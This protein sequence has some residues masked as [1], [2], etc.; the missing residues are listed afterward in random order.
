MLREEEPV[1]AVRNGPQPFFDAPPLGGRGQMARH[2]A[3]QRRSIRLP[4]FDY[5]QPGAYTV[6]ICTQPGAPM[7]GRITDGVV[8]LNDYGKV[9]EDCWRQIPA[10]IP[11]VE[12]DA[13]VV[14]PNH[15]HGI[16]V[17]AQDSRGRGTAC[18][19]PTERFGQPVPGSLP[20]L[21]RSFKSAATR[22]I[23]KLR[24]TPGGRVWQRGYYERVIRNERELNAVRRY[25][26]YNPLRRALDPENPA[27]ADR[28]EGTEP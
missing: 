14:M 1:R 12:L 4:Q 26:A 25:T 6:T 17:L 22:V 23:N 20:T 21:I 9:V 2:R 27:N 19:T 24:D 15:V 7:L 3:E 18:R 13:F 8:R 16:L 28:L 10:H 5:T 11:A